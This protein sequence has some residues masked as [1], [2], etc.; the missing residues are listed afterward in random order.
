MTTLLNWNIVLD[1]WKWE[2]L[3]QTSFS[4]SQDSNKQGLRMSV[5]PEPDPIKKFQRKILLNVGIRSITA[6]KTS[7][8]WCDWLNSSIE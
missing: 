5:T 8:D 7:R 3:K 1:T 2:N 6:F 4:Q